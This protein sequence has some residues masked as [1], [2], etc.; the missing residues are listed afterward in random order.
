M[1]MMPSWERASKTS[2]GHSPDAEG[3]N[4]AEYLHHLSDLWL[5]ICLM[6]MDPLY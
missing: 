5:F 4:I 1:L 2:H 6:E 3:A